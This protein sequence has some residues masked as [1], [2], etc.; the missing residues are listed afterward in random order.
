MLA[1]TAAPSAL[2]ASLARRLQQLLK[3]GHTRIGPIAL[4]LKLKSMLSGSCETSMFLASPRLH[5]HKTG[6]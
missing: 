4:V 2:L 3:R 6:M 5:R 1:T